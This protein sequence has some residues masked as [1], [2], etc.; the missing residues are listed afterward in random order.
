VSHLRRRSWGSIFV[1]DHAIM[2]LRRHSNNHV[3]VV[4]VKVTTLWN[5]KTER[6]GVVVTSQEI[7]RVV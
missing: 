5:I 2:E 1:L 3:I 4:W 7:V 6:W